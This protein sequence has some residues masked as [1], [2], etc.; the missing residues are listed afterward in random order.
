MRALEPPWGIVEQPRTIRHKLADDERRCYM[1]TRI[2]LADDHE[3]VLRRVR[4]MLEA[5][6]G[7]EVCGD[8]VDGREA[9]RKI[10]E[11]KPD[12]VI[13]DF[14]MPRMDGLKAARQIKQLVPEVPIVMF[15]MYAEQLRKEVLEHGI[16]LLIDKAYSDNLIVALEKLIGENMNELKAEQASAT[17]VTLRKPAQDSNNT[18]RKAR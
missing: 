4:A 7:W 18:L 8:A 12:V 16:A 9:V 1:P 11:L 13:L 2:F 17:A 3:S 15:S 10:E 6:P 5:H 14:A